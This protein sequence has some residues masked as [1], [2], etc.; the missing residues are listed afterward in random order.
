MKILT[1]VL[2]IF[3]GIASLGLLWEPNPDSSTVWGLV[4][5][6]LVIAQGIMVLN[7]LKK[8]ESK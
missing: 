2:V 3:S 7:H 6:G 8:E 4:F 1:W 5:A